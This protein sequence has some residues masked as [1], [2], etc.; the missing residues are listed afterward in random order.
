MIKKGNNIRFGNTIFIVE[1]VDGDDFLLKNKNNNILNWVKKEDI[2]KNLNKI[3]FS[4][5]IIAES[6]STNSKLSY[7]DDY[8]TILVEEKNNGT[9]IN[10]LTESGV[11]S[12]IYPYQKKRAIYEFEKYFKYVNEL[13]PY[14]LCKVGFKKHSYL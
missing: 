7:K 9:E 4:Y 8:I 6:K 1:N 5:N 2:L 3:N 14:K 13:T 10:I 12:K 11:Y